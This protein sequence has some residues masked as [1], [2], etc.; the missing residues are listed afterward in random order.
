MRREGSAFET[1]YQAL[2]ARGLKGNAALVA[3]MRKMLVVAFHHKEWRPVQAGQG[4][5]RC[6][7][8]WEW[9]LGRDGVAMQT[10]KER[11]AA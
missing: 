1:Y 9:E 4:M 10:Q 11:G 8:S 2:G 7:R 3:V 6:K 5:G